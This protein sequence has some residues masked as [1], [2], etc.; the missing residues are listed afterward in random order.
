MISKLDSVT[1]IHNPNCSKSRQA[2]EF[3]NS[4][5]I[6]PIEIDYL[7]TPLDANEILKILDYLQLSPEDIIRTKE[8]YFE[9]HFANVKL[10][11]SQIIDILEKNPILIQRPIIIRGKKAVIGRTIRKIREFLD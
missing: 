6:T 2:L 3:L 11:R 1:I 10:D 9:E 8:K 7:R 4:R 5:N